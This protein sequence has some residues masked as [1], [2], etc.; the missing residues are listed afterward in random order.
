[1]SLLRKLVRT[2]FTAPAEVMRGLGDA[3]DD[4]VNGYH[5]HDMVGLDTY[6]GPQRDCP[7]HPCKGP[8]R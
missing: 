8:K 7:Y 3:V 1:M 4:V 6:V 5:I 2:V